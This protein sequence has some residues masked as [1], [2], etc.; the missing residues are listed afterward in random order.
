MASTH[1]Q[2]VVFLHIEVVPWKT[3]VTQ[4]TYLPQECAHRDTDKHP[5]KSTSTLADTT[6]YLMRLEPT[7][8]PWRAMTNETLHQPPVVPLPC[9]DIRLFPRQVSTGQANPT[10]L[11]AT[12]IT[13]VADSR[14]CHSHVVY[15]PILTP[16]L[17]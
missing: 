12:S 7:A 8:P 6:R 1:Q 15:S 17:P 11:P 13:V 10:L 4:P 16:A 3:V 2:E 9:R 14:G 5:Q